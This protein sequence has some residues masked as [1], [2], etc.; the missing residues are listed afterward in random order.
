[1]YEILYFQ[2]Y[3]NYVLAR[4]PQLINFDKAA[5]TPADRK[6]AQIWKPAKQQ[7]KKKKRED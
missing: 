1:M 4:I 2:G 6:T 7:K 3:R 5:L